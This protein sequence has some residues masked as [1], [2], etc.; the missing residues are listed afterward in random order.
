MVTWK[1][2][3]SAIHVRQRDNEWIN[4]WERENGIVRSNDWMKEWEKKIKKEWM[5]AL[6]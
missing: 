2:V 6:E 4:E 1:P 3:K 5:N